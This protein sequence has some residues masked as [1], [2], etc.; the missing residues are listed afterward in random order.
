MA[1]GD[2]ISGVANTVD[3]PALTVAANVAKVSKMSAKHIYCLW[4]ICT[5]IHMYKASI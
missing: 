3:N 4:H 2:V 1:G 5:Q